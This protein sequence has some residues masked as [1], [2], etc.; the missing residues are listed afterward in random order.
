MIALLFDEIL[1]PIGDE[2]WEEPGALAV[3]GPSDLLSV[4]DVE[5]IEA[6][7]GE[8]DEGGINDELS[9]DAL[10]VVG[11]KLDEGL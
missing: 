11:D 3:D 4:F 6:V 5:T 7:V 1:V 10:A 8:D 9:D 2:F